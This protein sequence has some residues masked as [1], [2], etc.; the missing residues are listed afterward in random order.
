ML[1]SAMNTSVH[2]YSASPLLT[3]I[4]HVCMRGLAHM[5]GLGDDADGITMPGGAASNTLA[6]QTALSNAFDGAFR[7]LGVLGIVD[8]LGRA[9]RVGRGA[10]PAIL[11]GSHGHF[12]L[13]SAAIAAGLGSE[14][15]V[16]V[17]C[18]THGRMDPKAL[19]AQLAAM[20]HDAGHPQGYPFFVCATSGTT[21]LGAF[22]DLRAIAAL[23]RRYGCWLHVDASWGGPVVFSERWRFLLDGSD[24]ADSLT[25]NPHKLLCVPQ[26][27]S[28]FLVRHAH[29][30]YAH[31]VKAGYL[32]HSNN[33]D[34]ASKTLG[35]GRRGDALKLY[36]A[37]VRYGRA[38]FGAHIDAGMEL[39]RR[40]RAFLERE[41]S[42]EVLSGAE[43]QFLQVCFRPRGAESSDIRALY[44]A[45]QRERMYALDFAPV[46]GETYFRLV[47]HPTVPFDTFVAM[48]RRVEA[49]SRSLFR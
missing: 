27:C 49:L 17:P 31:S 5:F 9:G 2:V 41:T 24:A 25:I 30:L 7:T 20:A 35:C 28:F 4:E 33:R 43:P 44:D 45:L 39:S 36:L 18:D 8:H 29:T 11:T 12:S 32:F 3:E 34:Q 47:V 21:V 19:E 23:C 38:G 48:I 22:D 15:V 37:W 10:R 26:Q 14:A 40:V 1:L 13:Q 42:F 46:D 16:E 6:L